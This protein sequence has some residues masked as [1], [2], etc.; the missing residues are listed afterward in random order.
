MPG[1][2]FRLSFHSLV[3]GSSLFSLEITQTNPQHHHKPHQHR[4]HQYFRNFPSS[5]VT[6]LHSAPPPPGLAV[7][8]D[9]PRSARM[10]N[11]KPLAFGLV[12]FG[13]IFLFV[14]VD[15]IRLAS[16]NINLVRTS[17]DRARLRRARCR[18]APSSKSPCTASPAAAYVCTSRLEVCVRY[19]ARRYIRYV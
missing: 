11:P 12:V 18:R 1:G 5:L 10:L 6:P 13:W 14:V 3:P 19:P 4:P 7:R 16:C 2:K 15:S 17:S 9:T 8:H